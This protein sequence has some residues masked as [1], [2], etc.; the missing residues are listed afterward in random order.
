MRIDRFDPLRPSQDPT[1]SGGVHMSFESAGNPGYDI[2]LV[3]GSVF[4]C[5]D[6]F[7]AVYGP[8]GT[9]YIGQEAGKGV[10]AAFNKRFPREQV[11]QE[12]K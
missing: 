8:Q 11:K 9:A 2:F 10:V 5:R 6:G 3:E 1:R 4:V 7:I 12:K